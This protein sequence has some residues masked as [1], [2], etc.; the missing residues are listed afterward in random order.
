MR[1]ALVFKGEAR[2]ARELSSESRHWAED[3]SARRAGLG[4]P[5]LSGAGKGVQRDRGTGGS[6]TAQNRPGLPKRHLQK[7]GQGRTELLGS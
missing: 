1:S 7:T 4:K 2:G 5:T 3:L 6:S